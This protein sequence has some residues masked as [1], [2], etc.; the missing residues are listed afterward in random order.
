[1]GNERKSFDREAYMSFYNENTGLDHKNY[2]PVNYLRQ[3]KS[4]D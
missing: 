2:P 3:K 1:M 4:I